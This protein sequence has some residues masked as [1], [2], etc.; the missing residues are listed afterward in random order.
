MFCVIFEVLPRPD[1]WDDY[2]GLAALL[3]PE[4]VR[5]DGFIDNIRYRSLRRPG[6]VLS[7]S[8]WRD[9]KALVRWRTHAL[10]HEVQVR[11]R[12][13]VFGDYHLRVGAVAAD[14]HPPSGHAVREWSLDETEVGPAKLVGIVEAR[15]PPGLPVDA[16]PET[17]AASL[18]APTSGAG[19][20]DW[21]VF[22]AVLTPG[23]LLL[24]SSWRDAAAAADAAERHGSPAAGRRRR[25]RIVRDYG[26]FDRREAPQY[27]PPLSCPADTPRDP[28]RL[29]GPTS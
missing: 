26:M 7:L 8:T 3:R 27:Y 17:I 20:T 19:L 21:D 28:G 5:V 11:G 18:G 2:L 14:T 29:H 15:Q 4:L 23:D 6:Y 10:H 25:V 9:E 12:S 13:E 1:R 22:D 16:P 24:L